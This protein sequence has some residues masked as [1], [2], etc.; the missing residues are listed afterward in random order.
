MLAKPAQIL[1]ISDIAPGSVHWEAPSNIALIKYW[2]K[3][4]LQLPR[5]PNVSLTL[6]EA[7]TITDL[8]W[9]HRTAQSNNPI[10]LSLFYDKQPRPDFAKRV[11]G[12]FE[13][14]LPYFPWLG[15][16]HWTVETL[17]TFPHGAGIASSA[18]AMA[19]LAMCLVDIEA[20]WFEEEASAKTRLQKASFLARLGS[21]SAGRSVF[22]KA[23]A[24]GKASELAESSDD[25]ALPIEEL[26]HPVFEDYQDS[27]LLVSKAEKSVS[28]SAGHGLMKDHPYAPARYRLAN[29]R[30]GRMLEILRRGELDDFCTLTEADALDLHAL[31]MQSDPP[32]LLLE[33]ATLEIIK[34]VRGFRQNTGLP[35]CFTLDAGPN[36]HLLYPKEH[37]NRVLDWLNTEIAPQLP[38]GRID[39][40]VGDGPSN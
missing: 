23:A 10:S 36:V 40:H 28:S 26:L 29:S 2:G 38:G 21:G 14:L 20:R 27:I 5:N 9:T 4:G 18:S 35:V 22:A 6:S 34:A 31:M 3:H 32:Y 13:A 11:E 15:Q 30:F 25:Y 1:D 16:W 19:A 12:Y 33:P 39:D 7:R 8:R 17:N 24:W 37:K